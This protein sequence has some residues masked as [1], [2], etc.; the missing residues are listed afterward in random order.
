[1]TDKFYQN[2]V[3]KKFPCG[4]DCHKCPL[5][6]ECDATGPTACKE[7]SYLFQM[8][9]KEKECISCDFTATKGIICNSESI[10]ND[11]E[12]GFSFVED[13]DRGTLF[14]NQKIGYCQK[15]SASELKCN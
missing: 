3:E 5:A 12:D 15:C 1:M 2:L 13:E 4:I 10:P 7:N 6:M 8:W 9:T 11:C 14:T